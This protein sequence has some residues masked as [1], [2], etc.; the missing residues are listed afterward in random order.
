MNQQTIIESFAY[1][2]TD[3]FLAK[4]IGLVIS[5]VLARLLSPETFGL[6][7]IIS[8]FINLAQIFVQ[9]GFGSA[10][11]QNKT[12]SE[13]DY[14]TVF[15][16]SL[17][18]AILLN[19]VLFAFAPLIAAIYK[20]EAL[21]WPLRVMVLSLPIGALNSVQNA[22]LQREMRFRQV[23]QCNLIATVISGAIGIATAYLGA[24][25]WS[26]VIYNLSGTIIATICMLAADKWYPR[27][28][29]SEERVKVFWSF[30]WKMVVS[31]FLCSL[32]NDIR[33]LAIGKKFSMTELAHYSKGQQF[34]EVIASTLDTTIQTVMLPIMSTEQDSVKRL[35]EIL[36]NTVSASM[37]IVTPVMLGLAAVARTL[38][39]LLLTDKWNACIPFMIVFCISYL[40]LPIMTSNLSL[41]KAMG[42]S[43]VYMKT[44]FV[45]RIVMLAILAVTV[46]CFDSVT[47]IVVGYGLSSVLDIG[48]I[49][50]T[51][52]RLT[53]LKWICQL[54]AIWKILLCGAL[55]TL[56]VT[57][58][59]A[60]V[61]PAIWKLC[62]QI[63][64]GMI[65][66]A[67]CALLFRLEPAKILVHFLKNQFQ[68]QQKD[69]RR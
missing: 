25:L 35:K 6:L 36:L 9:G 52:E 8:V 34:P 41:I 69:A 24:E 20:D 59:D 22:K 32:Y 37:F 44:E 51:V 2:F 40:T 28:V 66:Y 1:K 43:D 61:L 7:A 64:S 54:K 21:V 12:T 49:M 57:S 27:F 3:R 60:L 18:I 65:S 29:F 55:M 19:A 46:I 26:L 68:I 56:I 15:F 33:S 39:P 62:V 50:L 47:A 14:S 53:G 63:V 42:R 11:V 16:L 17:G 4:G 38:I 31:G 10:L 30:G 23:M 45:R 58:L 48:I 67:C 13:D 5:I